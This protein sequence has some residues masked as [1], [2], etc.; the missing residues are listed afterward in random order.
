M[1]EFIVAF[2]K[3]EGLFTE[4][5]GK[6]IYGLE[7]AFG[8]EMLAEVIK[9]GAGFTGDYLL[10]YT[11]DVANELKKRYFI[12][13]QQIFDKSAVV[14]K[15]KVRE[16]VARIEEEIETYTMLQTAKETQLQ[17][18]NNLEAYEDYLRNV[19]H[20]HVATPEGLQIDEILQRE[21]QIVSEKFTLQ[22]QEIVSDNVAVHEEELKGTAALN[23]QRI[24]EKV[25][26]A[27]TILEPLPAL[28]HVQ[29]EVI[30]KRRRVETKQFTVALFGAFSAGKSS[31]ANALLGEKVL[32]V[33]PNPTTATINQILPVTEEK[34]HGTV[35]V[36]FKS[37][38][39][40][41]EDM[42]AVYKLFHYEIATLDEALAQIDKVMKYPSP[43]GKQNNI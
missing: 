20:D 23:I 41:L 27:E 34:P 42:K 8:P 19:W 25:K 12:K 16:A 21:K 11:A 3:E 6:D 35:I 36:Q 9:Q 17:Y 29:Q 43:T 32:P 15:Q 33:S 31:F 18:S 22:E 30:E 40:L 39:A 24:L 13:A 26:K 28:K 5:I 10:L 14:L 7:I 37:K 1:K 38:Q 2:L 4:E